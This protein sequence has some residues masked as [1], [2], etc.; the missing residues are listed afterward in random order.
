MTPTV[1]M[2]VTIRRDCDAL[3]PRD[4]STVHLL[5]GQRVEYEAVGPFW[6]CAVRVD[7][8]LVNVDGA[9]VVYPKG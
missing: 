7:G 5:A 3:D 6:V 4:G 1:D 2:T 8:R 9:D